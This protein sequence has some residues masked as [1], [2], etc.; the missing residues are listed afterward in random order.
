ML[1]E[2]DAGWEVWFANDLDGSYEG[3]PPNLTEYAKHDR[4][5]KSI[6]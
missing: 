5:G 3:L 2:I 6:Q 4:H 1:K